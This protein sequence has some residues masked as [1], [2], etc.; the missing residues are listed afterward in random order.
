MSDDSRAELIA[1][2]VVLAVAA[3]FLAFAAGP[4]LMPGGA[5]AAN[6]CQKKTGSS[7]RLISADS[8]IY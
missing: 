3:G 7:A 8:Y 4:R 5:A 1:G 2:A 6:D